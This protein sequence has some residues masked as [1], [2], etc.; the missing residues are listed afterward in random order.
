MKV[1]KSFI[2]P[3]N[4]LSLQER[5][6]ACSFDW[7]NKDINDTKI[8]GEHRR[9]VETEIKLISFSD[10]PYRDIGRDEV[11]S[12][13]TKNKLSASTIYELLDFTFFFPEFYMYPIYALGTE[14]V[15]KYM[16]IVSAYPCFNFSG[17]K[18]QL[19]LPWYTGHLPKE[20]LFICQEIIL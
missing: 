20:T 2:L 7:V 16:G 17:K 8:K 15:L 19:S 5:I 6:K 4:S 13:L 11:F 12:T 3:P 14:V 1:E 18:K 9:I 10:I